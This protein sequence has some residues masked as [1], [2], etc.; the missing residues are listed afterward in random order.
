MKKVFLLLL[1]FIVVGTNGVLASDS[2]ESI[3]I[4]NK[5]RCHVATFFLLFTLKTR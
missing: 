3:T 2:Y 5:K 1:L 4:N